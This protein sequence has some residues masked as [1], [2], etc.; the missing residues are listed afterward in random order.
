[1]I[2]HFENCIKAALHWKCFYS[3]SLRMVTLTQIFS[4][5]TYFLLSSDSDSH[6]L[7]HT[8]IVL[9]SILFGH[10]QKEVHFNIKKRN[11]TE[12]WYKAHI[13]FIIWLGLWNFNSYTENFMFIN[14]WYYNFMNLWIYP[15][16]LQVTDNWYAVLC[17]K[18]RK[19]MKTDKSEVVSLLLKLGSNLSDAYVY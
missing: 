1:M 4:L 17:T 13:I 12:F 5:P 10:T 16:Y 6:S 2:Q 19:I 15:M 7:H 8:A 18:V 3:K 14:T 11:C 9:V